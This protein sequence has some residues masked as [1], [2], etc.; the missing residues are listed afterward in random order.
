MLPDKIRPRYWLKCRFCGGD[1]TATRKDAQYCSSSCRNKYQRWQKRC[2]TLSHR[3]G[4]DM[5]ELGKYLQFQEMTP[6]VAE[7]LK[8]IQKHVDYLFSCYRIGRVR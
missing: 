1:F 3:I 8:G 2:Q 4:Q 5:G 7:Y 6:D